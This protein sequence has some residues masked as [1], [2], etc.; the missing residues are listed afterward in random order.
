MKKYSGQTRI[1][2]PVSLHKRLAEQATCEGVSLNTYIIYLLSLGVETDQLSTS[3]HQSQA[4]ILVDDE[5]AIHADENSII[6]GSY[7]N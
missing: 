3:S 5:N 2:I 4:P 1:R 7:L 6:L